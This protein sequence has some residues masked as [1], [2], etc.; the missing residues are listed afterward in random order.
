[1]NINNEMGMVLFGLSVLYI[2]V[3]AINLALLYSIARK[4]STSSKGIKNL[5][6]QTYNRTW[7]RYVKRYLK[8]DK[9]NFSDTID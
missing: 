5:K 8:E 1:M 7:Q 9:I 4:V 3:Y 6:F 2:I